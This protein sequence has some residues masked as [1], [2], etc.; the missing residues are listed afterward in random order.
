MLATCATLRSTTVVTG[1][2][3]NQPGWPR[4]VVAT[5]DLRAAGMTQPGLLSL[6]VPDREPMKLASA[7]SELAVN[8]RGGPR[9]LAAVHMTSVHRH[10]RH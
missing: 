5:D 10:G 4:F 1:G 9:R 2:G 3:A 6:V 8:W 7:Q